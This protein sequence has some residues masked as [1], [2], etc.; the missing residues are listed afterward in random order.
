VKVAL[1]CYARFLD[2]KAGPR[3]D[4]KKNF[5]IVTNTKF[6]SDAIQYANCSGMRLTGWNY[7]ADRPLQ[8][9]IEASGSYPVTCLSAL[10]PGQKRKL[11]ERGVALVSEIREAPSALRGLGLGRGDV[12]AV[13]AE[14]DALSR[15]FAAKGAAGC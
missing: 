2:L 6:T 11:L 7:P 3:G 14:A 10:K 1:Y 4:P 12:A 15:S 5:W 9:F 13:V 8:A